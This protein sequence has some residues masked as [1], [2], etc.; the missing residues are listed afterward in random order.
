MV[1]REIW[2]FR[3]FD[4]A[5]LLAIEIASIEKAIAGDRNRQ[6]RKGDQTETFQTVRDFINTLKLLRWRWRCPG[7]SRA[8]RDVSILC[9]WCSQAPSV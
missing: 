4:A 7:A 5:S 3:S 9:V 6:H 2:I 8:V 1:G